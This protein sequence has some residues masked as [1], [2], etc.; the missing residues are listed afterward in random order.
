MDERDILAPFGPAYG[1]GGRAGLS[2]GRRRREHLTWRADARILQNVTLT[3]GHAS[4]D[5]AA[6]P[7]PPMRTALRLVRGSFGRLLRYDL[8]FKAAG[9]LVLSPLAGLLLDALLARSGSASVT[10]ADIPAFALSPAGAA[11]LV[12][13]LSVALAG[14]FAEQAGMLVVLADPATRPIRALGTVAA[15]LPRLLTVAA[16]A[17]LGVLVA[18][19]PLLV[20]VAFLHRHYLSEHDIN[21]YLATR[22]PEWT[23]ALLWAGVLAV[24]TLGILAVLAV[25][26][27][28]AVPVVLFERQRGFA[29]LRRSAELV[30]G[31]G[32]AVARRILGW[33]V[34]C[35]A[36]A[37]LL[38]WLLDL[39]AGR[40]LDLLPT[41]RAQAIGTATVLGFLAVAVFAA[42]LV[43]A[44]G[45][46]ALTLRLYGREATVRDAPARRM[47]G[48]AALAAC[49]LAAAAAGSVAARR[50]GDGLER[51]RGVRVTAHRGSSRA[52]PE[53][54]LAAIRQAI[55]DGADFCEIDVQEMK[56][57]TIVVLHD[58][59]L[60]RI[61]GSP[62]RIADATYD[63]VRGL[64]IGSRLDP[65]FKDERIPTLEQAVGAARGRLK[66]NV[67]LKYHGQERQLEERVVAILRRERFEDQCVITSLEAKGLARVR[68]L[69]PELRIGQ[70]ITVALGKVAGLDVD[71]LSM[72]A[73]QATAAQVRA[74]RNAG[75]DTHVWTVN[76][77]EQ[78][79]RMIERGVDN[80]ITDLPALLREV[81][82]ERAAMSDAELLLLALGRKLRE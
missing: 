69:A 55:E 63:D 71:F 72:N 61:A 42:S 18:V 48:W 24:P 73:R 32:R 27:A 52:A 58:T 56:D 25:R 50:V 38:G 17:V 33:V 12:V 45:L 70:I 13:A 35:V 79:H 7:V 2:T 9:L 29:A 57:G 3:A 30:R 65:R 37:A 75:L 20:G 46:A 10:N 43:A 1:A 16:A 67:E 44:G 59:D 76:D 34:V 6:Y 62:T 31:R 40:L 81:I 77:R 80:V 4:D 26:W 23:K 39:A 15:A 49:A 51:S 11:Y 36:G 54:S 64:D 22:P 28:F 66:L 60:M 41:P 5:P 53:N 74:N 78:M 14:H 8:L 68:T 82:E 21:W 19:A 47:A